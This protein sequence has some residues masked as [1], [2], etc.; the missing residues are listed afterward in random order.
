M[1]G[2]ELEIRIL[3]PDLG[4]F[5]TSLVQILVDGKSYL[6]D[7]LIGEK[8]AALVTGTVLGFTIAYGLRKFCHLARNFF[9]NV[10]DNP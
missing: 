7:L 6:K 1:F 8:V 10:N 9:L 5:I 3:V 2:L 4:P